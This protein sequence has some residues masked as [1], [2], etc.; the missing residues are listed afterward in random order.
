MLNF[1]K[2][3]RHRGDA[4]SPLVSE[5]PDLQIRSLLDHPDVRRVMGLDVTELDDARS[6]HQTAA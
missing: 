4:P 6:V 1:L 2:R 3:R 5:N